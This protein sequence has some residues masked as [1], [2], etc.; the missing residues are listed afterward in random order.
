MVSP[1]N[2]SCYVY[3]CECGTTIKYFRGTDEDMAAWDAVA[4]RDLVNAH[5]NAG[6]EQVE[7]FEARDVRAANKKRKGVLLTQ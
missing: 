5:K 2:E 6:H 7:A 1:A 3:A 4:I